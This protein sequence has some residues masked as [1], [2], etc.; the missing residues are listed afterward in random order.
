[1]YAAAQL[2]RREE[3][4]MGAGRRSREGRQSCGEAARGMEGARGV[5]VKLESGCRERGKWPGELVEQR[6]GDG[7]ALV[8]KTTF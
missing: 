1:M 8:A 6:T 3:G 7:F 4:A 2:G 5:V